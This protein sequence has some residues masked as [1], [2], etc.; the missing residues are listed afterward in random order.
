MAEEKTK[1]IEIFDDAFVYGEKNERQ[2]GVQEFPAGEADSLVKNGYGKFVDDIKEKTPA[3]ELKERT[4]FLIE[5]G[6]E[7]KADSNSY[8]LGEHSVFVQEIPKLDDEKFFETVKA[9]ADQV[10]KD[11]NE[12]PD[13]TWL[14]DDLIDWLNDEEIEFDE[15]V[16]KEDLLKLCEDYASWDEEQLLGV[17]TQNNVEA[18][19][20]ESKVELFNKYLKLNKK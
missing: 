14:K 11:D 5:Q 6:F 7:F 19:A 17:L 10:A 9:I 12:V 20:E 1:T 4:D 15:T 2:T 8:R 18:T 3:E 13:K 16:K